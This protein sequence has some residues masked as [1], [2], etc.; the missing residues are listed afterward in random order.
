MSGGYDGMNKWITPKPRIHTLDHLLLSAMT[1][2]CCKFPAVWAMQRNCSEAYDSDS[3]NL[4]LV[5]NR[6]HFSNLGTQQNP[7][8]LFEKA[9]MTQGKQI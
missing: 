9:Q 7:N 4:K 2:C 3:H 1:P 6:S 8:L 5:L